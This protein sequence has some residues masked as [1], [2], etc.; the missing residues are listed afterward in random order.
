MPPYNV[1]DT[2]GHYVR[3]KSARGDLCPHSC[4]Q[5][6][7]RHPARLPAY[8]PP[9]MLKQASDNQLAEH[10]SEH[11]DC[12][13]CRR[14]IEREMDRRDLAEARQRGARSRATERGETVEHHY[15]TAERETRGSMVNRKGQAAGVDPRSLFTG[16]EERARRYASD[17]LLEHWQTTGRPTAAMFRGEDTRVQP[18]ATAWKRKPRGVRTQPATLQALARHRAAVAKARP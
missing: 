5:G 10:Y 17:E 2:L 1:R 9:K 13:K 14:Q 11:G 15:V 16:S 7:R 4:C 8:I 18:R 3:P 6:K 12:P